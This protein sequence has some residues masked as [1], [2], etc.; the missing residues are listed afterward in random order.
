MSAAHNIVEIHGSF[1]DDKSIV[2]WASG[3]DTYHTATTFRIR[4]T[5][6]GFDVNDV[7]SD[8]PPNSNGV[9]FYWIAMG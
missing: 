9:V 7:E 2:Y 3:N 1:I 4:T 5:A 6:D 8:A